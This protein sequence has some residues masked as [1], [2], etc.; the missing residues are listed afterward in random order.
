MA[1][2]KNESV[3][4][5]NVPLDS[6]EGTKVEGIREETVEAHPQPTGDAETDPEGVD[7]GEAA[8]DVKARGAE[9]IEGS[10]GTAEDDLDAVR[11]GAEQS[12]EGGGMGRESVPRNTGE[13]SEGEFPRDEDEETTTPG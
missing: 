12:A 13:T 2:E 6:D 1:D 9:A 10:E 8:A 5:E 11:R 4:G 3:Y 7:S